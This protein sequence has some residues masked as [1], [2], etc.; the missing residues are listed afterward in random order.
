ME[1]GI[2]LNPVR[3]T[4]AT[5]TIRCGHLFHQTCLTRWENMGKNTCPI[6]RRVFNAKTYTVHMTIHNNITGTSNTVQLTNNAIMSVF[7]VFEL[8]LDME[9]IDLERLFHDLG[10]SMSDFDP[11]T[12]HTE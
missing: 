3:E 1:C 2:C 6:C 11:S 7:D 8:Q 10:M 5:P 12:F 9:P 4:R